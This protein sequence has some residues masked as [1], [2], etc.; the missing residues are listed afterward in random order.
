MVLTALILWVGHHVGM[1]VAF[2]I[3]CW[4]CLALEVLVTLYSSSH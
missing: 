2:D 4:V 3:I 1:P